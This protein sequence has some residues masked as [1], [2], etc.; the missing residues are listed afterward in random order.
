MTSPLSTAGIR[1]GQGTN[2]NE[3]LH[4]LINDITSSCRYSPQLAYTRLTMAFYQHNE[5]IHKKITGNNYRSIQEYALEK[6]HCRPQ[7]SFG[8]NPQIRRETITTAEIYPLE[9]I[10]TDVDTLDE[11]MM[12]VKDETPTSDVDCERYAQLFIMQEII[13]QQLQESSNII[14]DYKRFPFLQLAAGDLLVQRVN[15]MQISLQTHLLQWKLQTL[16]PPTHLFTCMSNILL[17]LMQDA[18]NS[19]KDFTCSIFAIDKFPTQPLK[20]SNISRS[21]SMTISLNFRF[22]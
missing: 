20:C 17:H 21:W 15:Q 11:Q 3:G 13:F 12:V 8:I 7:E 16:T 19:L 10:R 6:A 14:V 5:R 2:R 1:A 4:C 9:A 18:D 22:Q